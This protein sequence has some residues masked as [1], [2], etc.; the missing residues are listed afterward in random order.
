MIT[1][2]D[3]HEI[4]WHFLTLLVTLGASG[5]A[6]VTTTDILGHTR[7]QQHA[8]QQQ[9][10]AARR[11]LATARKNRHSLQ[12]HAVEIEQMQQRNIL[13]RADSRLG[14]IEGLDK[15][16]RQ[17]HVLNFRYTISPQQNYRLP[18]NL[19]I[20]NINAGFSGMTLHIDLL[21]EVQ[22]T[23]FFEA[24]HA[25]VPGWFVLDQCTI[26][27]SATGYEYVADSVP[28]KAECSG[29]WLTLHSG[30]AIS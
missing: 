22:L 24:L 1:L 3:F 5:S 8:F 10:T 21:H 23:I 6:M 17:K 18:E 13:D 12:T 19:N 28:L 20:R 11:E 25:D 2:A 26:E 9:L 16:H 7:V 14:W 29:G 15:I 30:N 4:K 27:R